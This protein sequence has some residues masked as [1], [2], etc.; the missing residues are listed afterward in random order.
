MIIFPFHQQ[1]KKVAK[2]DMLIGDAF[3][4]ITPHSQ[5]IFK[6]AACHFHNAHFTYMHTYVLPSARMVH[7]IELC[8]V[9]T[10]NEVPDL[11][12]PDLRSV[13]RSRE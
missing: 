11:R 9:E 12:D 5:Y 1:N 2:L 7:Y 6:V 8:K 13:Q 3:R 10:V 4:H